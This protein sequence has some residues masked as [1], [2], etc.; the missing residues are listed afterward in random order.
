MLHQKAKADFSHL[1]KQT[2]SRSIGS[3]LTPR[4]KKK[5]TLFLH[6]AQSKIHMYDSSYFSPDTL[7]SDTLFS[8]SSYILTDFPCQGSDMSCSVLTDNMQ[9]DELE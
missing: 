8:F 5:K 7:E 2:K 6:L 9:G 4:E 1:N 3:L